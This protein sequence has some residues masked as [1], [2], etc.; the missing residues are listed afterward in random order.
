MSRT[1]A[2]LALLVAMTATSAATAITRDEI[3]ERAAAYA[4]QKWTCSTKN[5][6]AS[7]SGS[8]QSDYTPGTYTGL[9]Y[10]WGGYVELDAFLQ[11][12]SDGYGAG[13]HSKN[14]VLSCTTGLDC[15]GFVSKCWK[16]GHKSTSTMYTITVPIDASDVLP[17]DAYNDAGSHVV[18]WVELSPDGA[19][20][21]YEASGSASKVRL[22][23]SAT[24]SYLNGY[25]PIRYENV[26]DS[27]GPV[28]GTVSDPFVVS[29]FP[30]HHEYSTLK[31][32]SHAF[33][34]YACMPPK[35]GELGPEVVYTFEVA[36]GGTFAAH[37]SDGAGVDIDLQLLVGLDPS[38]CLQRHDTDIGPIEIGPGTY[39]LIADSW[40]NTSGSY[41]PG[42]YV[43][44]ATFEP[45]AAPPPVD[46]GSGPST[47]DVGGGQPE[48]AGG[49]P[50]VAEEVTWDAGA[51]EPPAPEVWTGSTDSVGPPV[52]HD[53]AGGSI[54]IPGAG[55]ETTS[56]GVGG[57]GFNAGGSSSLPG[58]SQQSARQAPASS[59]GCS[60]SHEPRAPWAL[61]LVLL[62]LAVRGQ[63]AG[64]RSHA[65]RT[66][67]RSDG[68]RP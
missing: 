50:T 12:I 37:V 65:R 48:D 26:T 53:V 19:P 3:L 57:P 8:Y 25:V 36:V 31:T 21:F 54:T 5:M 55:P 16:A 7:C 22:N 49:T 13:S 33:D 42:S 6:T 41:Y 28:K 30:F 24:W 9:P 35:G 61:L 14:G 43:L 20:V 2:A 10:D 29:Q 68:S 52:S 15:S 46:A 51:I 59:D 64:S 67:T 32:G 63:V 40:S 11:Q 45:D 4:E 60:A 34:S 62:L 39:G 58:P 38:S 66:C 47:E 27:L 44:D 17:G 1:P 23:T 56:G 18:L